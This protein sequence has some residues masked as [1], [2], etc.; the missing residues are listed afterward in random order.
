MENS[1]LVDVK[2][3]ISDELDKIKSWKIPDIVDPSQ[4]KALR[5]PD[6][7][8]NGKVGGLRKKVFATDSISFIVLLLFE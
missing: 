6:S 7:I 1:R 8:A 3:R 5:L 2:P 4:L